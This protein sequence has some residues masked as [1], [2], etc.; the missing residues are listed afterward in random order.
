MLLANKVVTVK[1]RQKVSQNSEDVSD[2]SGGSI[3]KGVLSD[4][5]DE[6]RLEDAIVSRCLGRT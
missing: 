6:G 4:G 3:R 2:T 1:V 5:F